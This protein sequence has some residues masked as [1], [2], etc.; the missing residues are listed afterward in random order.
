MVIIHY[1][2]VEGSVHAVSL[3]RIMMMMRRGG[4]GRRGGG[5]K[6]EAKLQHLGGG[7]KKSPFIIKS[8]LGLHPKC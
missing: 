4:G 8:P 2:S 3:R 6:D 1:C 5:R 7:I